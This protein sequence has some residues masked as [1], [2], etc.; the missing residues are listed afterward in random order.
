VD[1]IWSR[2][3]IEEYGDNP[4][5]IHYD[6]LKEYEE[7]AEYEEREDYYRRLYRG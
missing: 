2:E 4:K 7:Y 5:L 6:E 1:T 3:F